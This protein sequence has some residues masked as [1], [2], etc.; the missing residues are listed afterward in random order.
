VKLTS[1][2]ALQR[3][4]LCLVTRNCKTGLEFSARQGGQVQRDLCGDLRER[5]AHARFGNGGGAGDRPTDH[6]LGAFHR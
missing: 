1:R 5:N 4:S 2:P 6:N 3:A